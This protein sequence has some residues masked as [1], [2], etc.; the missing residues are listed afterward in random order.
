M[1]YLSNEDVVPFK[2][3]VRILPASCLLEWEIE[4]QSTKYKSADVAEVQIIKVHAVKVP[5]NEIF[6]SWTFGIGVVTKL[7]GL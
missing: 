5:N 7:R 4:N 6:Q 2:H 3:F 1:P